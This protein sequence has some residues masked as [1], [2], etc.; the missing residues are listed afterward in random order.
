MASLDV[1]E[2]LRKLTVLEKAN[3][4]AGSDFLA[5]WFSLGRKAYSAFLAAASAFFLAF[6]S[7]RF[8]GPF[9][10][11]SAIVTAVIKVRLYS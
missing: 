7:A 4:L 11:S 8:E 3:L 9:C 1:E 2:T 6:S 10:S 5:A